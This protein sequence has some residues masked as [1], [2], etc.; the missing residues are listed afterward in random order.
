[1]RRSDCRRLNDSRVNELAPGV[2]QR[3]ICHLLGQPVAQHH[4]PLYDRIRVRIEL[5][6]VIQL[7]NAHRCRLPHVAI[8][9]F[10][11]MAHRVHLDDEIVMHGHSV[12][13]DF[14]RVRYGAT[15]TACGTDGTARTRHGRCALKDK[16]GTPE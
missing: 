6:G 12:G 7:G 9:R 11:F 8:N 14:G 13:L 1:M 2:K 10:H 3:Y 4:R 5:I 16:D 15:G